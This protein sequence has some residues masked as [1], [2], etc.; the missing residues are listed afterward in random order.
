VL[1]ALHIVA[2]V[3][4][5][6]QLT[7]CFENQSSTSETFAATQKRQAVTAANNRF[8]KCERKGNN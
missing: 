4:Q 2:A 7:S 1:Y 8:S 5:Q 3:S 6:L